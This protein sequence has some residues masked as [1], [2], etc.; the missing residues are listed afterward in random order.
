MIHILQFANYPLKLI[1]GFLNSSLFQFIFSKKF[2]THKVLRGDLEKLPFPIIKREDQEFIIN[3]VDQAIKGIDKQKEL[4]DSIMRI[5]GLTDSEK[6][7]IM[8]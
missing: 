8:N 6:K 5:V 2:S 3:L 7:L 1:L 4:D